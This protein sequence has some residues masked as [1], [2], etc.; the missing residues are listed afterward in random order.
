M[1]PIF[2][3]FEASSLNKKSYPIEVAWSD[4]KGEI[5]SYLIRPETSWL[6]WEELAEKEVHGISREKLFDEGVS[7]EWLVGQMGCHL[8]GKNI[9]VDGGKFDLFWCQRLFH[10]KGH[11]GILPFFIRDFQDLLIRDFGI[12]TLVNRSLMGEIK[13]RVREQV[14]GQHR[15]EFDVLY[16]QGIY[17]QV[18][19]I[20]MK[21]Y[22]I[23]PNIL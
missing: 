19:L 2:M 12:W 5:E 6:D 17:Q 4:E 7:C 16:L 23:L 3:D 15:A 22:L 11:T 9:Y 8:K 10:Y 21:K 18:K 1:Q 20:H 13:L 14:G